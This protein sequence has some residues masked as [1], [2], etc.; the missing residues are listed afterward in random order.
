MTPDENS[1]DQ[2]DKPKDHVDKS[3]QIPEINSK[4]SEGSETENLIFSKAFLWVNCII[5]AVIVGY[6]CY[7]HF[8]GYNL[9]IMKTSE[10]KQLIT[11]TSENKQVIQDWL[12]D[13]KTGGD[14]I[15]YWADTPKNLGWVVKL[16]AV[17]DWE[18]L[19]E[20]SIRI[21]DSGFFQ[22]QIKVRIDSSTQGGIQI[23]KIWTI[24]ILNG[25][26]YRISEN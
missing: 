7:R 10:N 4:E 6:L 18:I 2:I 14:G 1:K 3:P 21:G 11:K 19:K 17:R 16:Y 9:P 24:E 25:K 26:I 5:I 23:T 12:N 20:E 13:L 15:Q 8:S 22:P